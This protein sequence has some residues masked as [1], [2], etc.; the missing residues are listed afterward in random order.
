MKSEK[1][2]EICKMLKCDEYI[3]GQGSKTILMLKNLKKIKLKL[4]LILNLKKNIS[5]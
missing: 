4:I 2:L 3:T 5:S 1:I